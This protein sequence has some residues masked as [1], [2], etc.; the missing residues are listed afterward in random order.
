ME[1]TRTL[2]I[3]AAALANAAACV[4][5]PYDDAPAAKATPDAKA[6]ATPNAKVDA[7]ATPVASAPEFV[8]VPE[9][10]GEV[11]ALVREAKVRAEAE[12]R[13]LVVYVGASWCEP[14]QRFHE[15]VERGELDG[16]L[17]NVRFLEFDA[18][19]HTP[20]L[21][22]AG[23]GGRLI[24]RFAMPGGDG[25]GTEAKIEGGPKGDAAVPQILKRL[26]QLLAT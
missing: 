12:S 21:D 22:A 24:P 23:Y 18:D 6:D 10:V 20:G 19:R 9:S 11:D 1:R 14:C 2:M 25:R 5:S 7:K 8:R 26:E 17:A 13:R 4:G 15:A 16:A 3:L